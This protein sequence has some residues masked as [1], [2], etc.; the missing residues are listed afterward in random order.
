[1]SASLLEAKQ[2]SLQDK[3][4]LIEQLRDD[5]QD[6]VSCEEPPAWHQA[7]LEERLVE[8]DQCKILGRDVD[9]VFQELKMEFGIKD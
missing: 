6:E 4:I 8:L 1:M 2:R 7:I 3:L 5:A 9:E